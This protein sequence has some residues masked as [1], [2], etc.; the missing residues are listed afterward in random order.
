MNRTDL[1][2]ALRELRVASGKQ[3]KVVARS[4]A[5]SPSKLSKIEN[6]ALP[7]SVFDVERILEALEVSVEIKAE[8]TEAARR[9]ATEATAW[10]IYRRT[11]LHKHQEEIQ[12]VEAETTLLR[13]FQPSCI[14][15]LLQIPE[16]VRGVQQGSELTDD[17]LEKMIGAR[18]R[19]QE[20][21]YDRARTFR[22]LITESVLRWRLIPAP[23]MAAQLDKLITMSRMPNIQIGIVPLSAPMPGLPT[24]S[25]ALFGGR[26]A[27][28]E[29]RHAEITTS[30]LRDIELYEEKFRMFDRVALS[31]EGMWDL[32]ASIRDDFLADSKRPDAQ[33]LRF[34]T[35][36]L[37]AAGIDPARFDLSA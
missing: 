35:E 30:E 17:A 7:P 33:P 1:G 29:I 31:G 28:I 5:M 12:A 20:V 16:Y 8:L 27:I 36:E 11:G 19:R 34:T 24:S 18:L 2:K 13:V 3:A 25:F 22:F 37:N 4:A 14:P 21:L 6:G 23:M 26:L 32:V 15:G 9:V 10:R